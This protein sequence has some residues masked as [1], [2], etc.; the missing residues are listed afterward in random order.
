[1]DKQQ[2]MDRLLAE[3]KAQGIDPAEVY[4]SAGS[5][6]SAGAMNGNIDS[7]KVS[8][9]QGL[10]LRGMYQGKMGYASTQA[11]DEEAIRQ[12]IEGVKEGALLRED[13]GAEEIYEGDAEYPTVVSYDETLAQVP[14]TAKLDA[15]LAIEKAALESVDT[16]KQC[17]STQLSTMS[18]E[19]YLRNSYGLNLQHK[20]NAFIAYTGAI[21]K[22]GDSTSTGMAFKCGRDFAKLDVKKLGEEAAQ[23][24]ASGLHAEPVPA[25]NYRMILR[26]DAMQSL[27]A[28]FCGI[29]SAENAQQ[30]L[31]LLKG[32]E[33]EKIAADCVTLMDD[34]LL[35][36]GFDS[37]PFD[38]EGVASKTKAVV[39]NG[40]LKTLL[41]NRKT[42]KKQGVA[43]TGNAL[44]PGLSAP[45]TVAPTNFFFKPGDKT[46]A[47]LE[48]DM[49]DGLVITDLSGLHAGA[50]MT[51]GDFSLLSKGYLLK[52]GKRV[53]PVE[54][55]TIAGNFYDVLKNIRAIGSDLIFPAS[56]VGSSSV[57]V[58]TLTAAGK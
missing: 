2:F 44:R 6:F 17:E 36:G 31:S 19:V 53:Q 23:E 58:G 56:G 29:F 9:R 43:S 12:L 35:E 49:S 41:H 52:D 26:Y 51:S 30:G 21:A 5:S 34:P 25:G 24:A 1:M 37:A 55:I 14:A 3:A 33:G 11:F 27:L 7:Y 15:V 46:L 32:R 13:E 20:D 40:V 50:N 42:A 48:S 4:F 57:D 18:G 47:E 8:T 45:I 54:Q 10:G 28:T 38:G 39:E 16:V 22:D